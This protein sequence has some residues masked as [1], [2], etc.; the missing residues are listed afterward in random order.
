[1]RA[2]DDVERLQHRHRG[3]RVRPAGGSGYTTLTC[4][5]CDWDV[6]GSAH[7]RRRN[8]YTTSSSSTEARSRASCTARMSLA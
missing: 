1:M 2:V 4:S 8:V 6:L 7:V 5:R 3:M